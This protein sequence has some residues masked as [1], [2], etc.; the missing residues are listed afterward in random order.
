MAAMVGEATEVPPN[1]VH[2]LGGAATRRASDARGR[3]GHADNFV[4]PP[5]A[6]GGKH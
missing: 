5:I 4:V 1:P 3:I 6:I 2:V